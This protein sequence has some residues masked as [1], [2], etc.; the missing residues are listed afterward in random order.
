MTPISS[1]FWG[2]LSGKTI[3]RILF[4]DALKRAVPGLDGRVLDIAG[5]T[6]P[7]YLRILP[8][9]LNWFVLISMRR[10]ELSRLI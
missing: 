3:G 1:A 10:L 8:Q 7:S 9:S 5:G 2:A 4:N 6:S